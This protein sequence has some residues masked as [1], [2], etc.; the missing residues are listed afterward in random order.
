LVPPL[1]PGLD[2]VL[3]EN[4]KANVV[5]SVIEKEDAH[6][7]GLSG[8]ARVDTKREYHAITRGLVMN[9]IIRRADP[10]VFKKLPT[11]HCLHF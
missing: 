4:I 1:L 3:A 2:S 11:C 7:P 9:E 10:K 8:K 5:G 6:S